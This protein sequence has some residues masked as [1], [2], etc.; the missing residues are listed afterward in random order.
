MATTTAAKKAPHPPPATPPTP[1]KPHLTPSSS[2]ESRSSVSIT[3]LDSPAAPPPVLAASVSSI[4]LRAASTRPRAPA[5][6]L[7][8]ARA[9]SS[10]W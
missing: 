2:G 8:M 4:S 1:N 7:L 3:L 10:F 6:I 5:L 9:W